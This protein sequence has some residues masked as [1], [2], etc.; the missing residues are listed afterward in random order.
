M[1]HK[2]RTL[3]KI[4]SYQNILFVG[5]KVPSFSLPPPYP[6]THTT[7]INTHQTISKEMVWSLIDDI[8]DVL[9]FYLGYQ[10]P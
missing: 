6:P 8:Y 10:R 9:C 3:L 2:V 5:V 7:Q 1:I 4:S